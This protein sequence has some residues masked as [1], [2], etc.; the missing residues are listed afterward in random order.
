MSPWKRG[1][2]QFF[3]S[4]FP[5]FRQVLSWRMNWPISVLLSLCIR[6][7]RDAQIGPEQRFDIGF[8]WRNR[9][10]L[11]GFF[12]CWKLSDPE[13]ADSETIDCTSSPLPLGNHKSVLHVCESGLHV[14][15]SVLHICESV[16]HVCESV[17]HICESVSVL[18]MGSS[19][20]ILD[21]TYNRRK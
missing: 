1:Q 5:H 16:L 14:C 21:S 10:R 12:R 2:I 6:N 9:T 3:Y 7:L 8:F 15:E 20:R 13:N 17:L 19:C 11:L 18:W 4:R